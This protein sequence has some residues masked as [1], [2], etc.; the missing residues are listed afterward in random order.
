MYMSVRNGLQGAGD[1]PQLE[2]CL[3]GMKKVLISVPIT[4]L[5]MVI[6]TYNSNSWYILLR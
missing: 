2:E 1:I 4:K 3:F 5:S 6:N